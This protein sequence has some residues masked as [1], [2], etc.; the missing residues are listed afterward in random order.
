MFTMVSSVFASVSNA[1][2]ICFQTYVAIIASGCFKTRS[3]VASPSLPFYCF[4]SVSGAR[5]RR[6]SPLAWVGAACNMWAIR[7]GTRDRGQRYGCLIE[8]LASGRPGASHAHQSLVALCNIECSHK[9]IYFYRKK[10][11]IKRVS[12]SK[13]KSLNY[14]ANNICL[15]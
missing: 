8:G 13:E 5:R 10:R 3:S 14:S 12:H 11:K 2:F 6:R 7:R 15:N 4:A 9:S 1:C